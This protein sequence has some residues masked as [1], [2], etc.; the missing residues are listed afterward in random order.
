MSRDRAMHVGAPE[1]LPDRPVLQRGRGHAAAVSHLRRHAGQR[2]VGQARARC[3]I[4]RASPTI[5]GIRCCRAT[6]CSPSSIRRTATPS[7][8]TARTAASSATTA[9]P[10]SGRASCRRPK[11][12][13]RRCA[14]TGRR[15]SSCRT[16]DKKTLYTAA[17]RVFK[18]ADRGQTWAVVSPDLSNGL[19]RDELVIM[20]VSGRNITL[21]RNDGMSSFGNIFALAESPR[22]AGLLYA[23][24]DDG[25]VQV[26]QDGG[27]TWANV[28]QR[29][30]RRAQAHVRE[31]PH[32]VGLCRGHGVRLVRRPPQRRLQ[33]VGLREHR[34]RRAPGA[35][36]ATTCRPDRST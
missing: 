32:A 24:T 8:R 14:G 6:A 23:G 5:T 10:A 3:A 20:G 7:T 13:S 34:F 15:R 31:P 11:R 22:K 4:A 33:A 12:A 29:D 9:R 28:T 30:R 17:N 36:S 35:R 27:A 25:N 1:Q 19:N 18:S 2:V 26:S 21:S 16:H